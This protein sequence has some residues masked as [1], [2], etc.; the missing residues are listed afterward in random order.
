LRRPFKQAEF[1]IMFGE[2]ISRSG[3][4]IDIGTELSVIAKAGAFYSKG[5]AARVRVVRTRR[6]SWTS[7]R[8][9]AGN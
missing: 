2:G 3:S 5:R 7:A 1:D 8:D 9:D 4:I 6:S